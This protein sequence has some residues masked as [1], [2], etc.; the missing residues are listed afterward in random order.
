MSTPGHVTSF[1]QFGPFQVDVVN[2]QL[3]RDGTPV[4]LA[5]KVLDALFILVEN[6]GRV[7]KKEDL[8]NFLWPDCFVEESSLT[9]IIFQLRKALGESAAK[10]QYIETIPKR[11]YRFIAEIRMVN[12]ELEKESTPLIGTKDN[13]P[14]DKDSQVN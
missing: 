3:L 6:S 7:L 2:R 5:P 9:Q 8:M 12:G 4:P 13:F 10:Q 11:G 1:Y 14:E